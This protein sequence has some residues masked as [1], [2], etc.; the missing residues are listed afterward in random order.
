MAI[1]KREKMPVHSKRQAQVGVLLFDKAFTKILAK[2]SDYSNI[3]LAK[4]AAELPENTEMNEHIIEL[5]KDKQPPFGL[6]YSLEPVE[7][8]ILKIYIKINSAN[9][10][11]QP[12]KS[13]AGV[14]IFFDRKLYRN[15]RLY[16]DY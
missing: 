13:P 4:N 14:P 2:Y 10:F 16:I 8:E 3:F 12:F 6:I 7:L 15:F 11:I 1:Q 5:E 9:G